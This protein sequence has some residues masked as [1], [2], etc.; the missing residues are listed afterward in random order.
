MKKVLIVLAC[1]HFLFFRAD[2][3]RLTQEAYI[4]MFSDLAVK[5]M[6]R[7]GVPA[8]VTLAQG[9]LESEFG[10]SLLVQKSNNHFGIKCKS[11][12]LGASVRHDDDERAECF[13]KYASAEES[14]IDHSD[15]LRSSPRYATLF[16]LRPTD[17]RGWAYG[18][19]Q[20][21]YATN[22]RYPELLIRYIENYNLQQYDQVALNGG[23]TII[24]ASAKQST[25]VVMGPPKKDPGNSEANSEYAPVI[26]AE[27][28]SRRTIN[29]SEAL[30]APKGTSL[31]A[32]AIKYK[33]KLS[34][35]LE[36]NDLEKDGL[37]QQD[38]FI[39]L[40][41]KQP[42]GEVD[43]CYS[44]EGE[45]LYD[46]SQRQG[47]WLKN[48]LEFNPVSS[49]SALKPGTKIYLKPRVATAIKDG[50]KNS[51]NGENGFVNKS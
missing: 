35:L 43:Y 15:F 51:V 6:I 50:G 25:P 11:S 39:F 5:E 32:I 28:F 38:Q 29:R 1:L 46:I 45:S 41:K 42:A 44:Q 21:G 9:L 20:A 18:L 30:F 31:L 10:N 26:V 49:P 14:Y 16:T 2:A 36:W 23:R 24:A 8:S 27:P 48:I 22:P 3:Q 13:R 17:Y 47:V 4:E 12:W 37:L 33:V 19:K 40:S 34:K 7:T